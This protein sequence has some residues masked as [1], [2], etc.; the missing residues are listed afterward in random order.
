[1]VHDPAGALDAGGHQND[2]DRTLGDARPAHRA[3]DGAS[4]ASRIRQG[5]SDPVQGR[6]RPRSR[7]CRGNLQSDVSARTAQ[8]Q[9][10]GFPPYSLIIISELLVLAYF[11][12]RY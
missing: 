12:V 5:P 1:M 11:A 10:L 3:R 8:A 7:R 6:R 9:Q 2:S 4:G